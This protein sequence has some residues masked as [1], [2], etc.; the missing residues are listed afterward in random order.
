MHGAR[1]ERRVRLRRAARGSRAERDLVRAPGQRGAPHAVSRTRRPPDAHT[2]LDAQSGT[3]N[4][5]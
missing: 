1:Q 2:A 4:N 5:T 3:I